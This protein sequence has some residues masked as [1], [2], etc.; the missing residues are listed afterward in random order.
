MFDKEEHDTDCSVLVIDDERVARRSLARH[1]EYLGC[2]VIEATNG[3][4]G[5]ELIAAYT[6]DIV[7]VDLRMPELDGFGVMAALKEMSPTTPVIVVSGTGEMQDVVEALRLGAW[8]FILKPFSAAILKHA[9]DQCREK[10]R[11]EREN[12]ELQQQLIRA[13]RTAAIGTIVRGISH[14]FSNINFTILG[15][16]SMAL[17]RED[18][19]APSRQ[20][21]ERIQRAAQRASNITGNLLAFSDPKPVRTTAEQL[22]KLVQRVVALA[23]WPEDAGELELN[24]R[25]TPPVACDVE[26]LTQVLNNLLSNAHHALLSQSTGRVTVELGTLEDQAFIRVSDNGC[27]IEAENLPRIFTPF[28]STKGVYAEEGSPLAEVPGLGL[29]LALCNSIVEAHGGE[30][31]VESQLGR[32]TTFTVLLP[33]G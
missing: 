15:S 17:E 7:I 6:P 8:D 2:E 11:L 19:S 29:G 10:L 16:A 18:T 23:R 26:M 24:I 31:R 3:R 1:L 30:L 5:L 4:E 20:Y 12:K 22:A 13:E 28:F 21:L 27:G 14:E 33:V 25:D 32:G 9:I